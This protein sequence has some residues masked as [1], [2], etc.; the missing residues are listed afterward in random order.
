MVIIN[1]QPAASINRVGGINMIIN[2]LCA[3]IIA[4]VAR[5]DSSRYYA[6]GLIADAREM[7]HDI[8]MSFFFFLSFI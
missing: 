8:K 2:Y 4:A 5:K 1:N 3:I 7:I 6:V